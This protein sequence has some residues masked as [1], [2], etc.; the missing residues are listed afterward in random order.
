MGNIVPISTSFTLP[1]GK[2]VT[3]ETGKLATQAHGSVVVRVEDTMLLAPEFNLSPL[4]CAM[5]GGEEYEL[6]FSVSQQDFL[7]LK[8]NPHFTPIGYFTEE[9]GLAQL[10]DQ[11][12]SIH[13]I[14]AQ[15]WAH[16]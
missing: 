11:A 16:F 9:H 8:G 6:L 7:T 3:I 1:D 2:K 13:E 15:G 10:M 14:K 12:G 4:T 5:N